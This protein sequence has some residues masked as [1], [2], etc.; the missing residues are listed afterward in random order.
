MDEFF[1]KSNNSV[2]AFKNTLI[3]KDMKVANLWDT[4]VPNPAEEL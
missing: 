4:P 3:T 1:K 2:V